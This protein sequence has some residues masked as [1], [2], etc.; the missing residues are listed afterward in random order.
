MLKNDG[1]A[2]IELSAVNITKTV[3]INVKYAEIPSNFKGFIEKDGIISFNSL[4]FSRKK[5][6]KT[7]E[8]NAINGLGHNSDVMTI[9]PPNAHS[10]KNIDDITAHAPVME[11]D[12]YTAATGKAYITTYCLPAHGSDSAKLR[13]AIGIDEQIPAIVNTEAAEY[14][15]TWSENVM[16]AMAVNRSEC[17]IKKAGIH[18][19]KLYMADA[20]LLIEKIVINTREFEKSYFG[21]P[22]TK[23]KI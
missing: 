8:W 2:R 4:N 23:I 11:F 16:R 15:R 20:G 13:Y 5:D 14:T 7:A 1:N 21:P 3:H 9:I 18:T 6:T 22:E 10:Y 17:V 12:F 19:L